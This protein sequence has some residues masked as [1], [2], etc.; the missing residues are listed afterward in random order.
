MGGK[1]VY[2]SAQIIGWTSY[3]SLVFLATYAE[4][5]KKLDVPFFINISS[6]IILGIS[7]THLMR[8]FYVKFNWL[9]IKLFPL[10]PRIFLSSL[11]CSTIISLSSQTI[12]VFLNYSGK[13]LTWLDTLINILALLILILFWNSVYFTFHFFQKSRQQELNNISLEASRNEIELKNLLAQLNPHFLF[14][15]LNSIRALIDI[16]PTKAKDAVT[17]LSALLR[18]SLAL[19]KEELVPLRA[20]LEM[21]DHYLEMEKIR[22]EER[23]SISWDTDNTMNHLQIPP[24]S[25]QTLVENAIKHGISHLV[26]GGS[27]SIR[28]T[29]ESEQMVLEVR[30][31]GCLKESIDPGIG[32]I[33]TRRRLDL[34]F[35]GKATLEL[36]QED[37]NVVAILT[38]KKEKE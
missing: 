34:Q 8:T 5:P 12:S 26:N 29:N 7:V 32:I 3:A 1:K 14:N 22:F 11:I 25:M 23:L 20:E 17:T 6:L 18:T 33:N 2:W 19:G 27:I 38:I 37:D 36:L 16:E 13:Y 31:T 30:N 24:F 10:I 21:I 15:S 4:D 9:E 28:T 35:K